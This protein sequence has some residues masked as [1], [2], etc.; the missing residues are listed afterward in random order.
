MEKKKN[1]SIENNPCVNP[2]E[3]Y[4]PELIPS[5][6]ILFATEMGTA[7]EFANQLHKE[8][9]EKLKLKA[10]I[11]NVSEVNSVQIFNENSLIVIIASTWGEGE[12]T[13]DCVDFNKMVKSKEFWDSFTNA[14]NLNVAI[15]GL[16]N[17]V[18]TFYNAQG[19]FFHKVFV[20]EHKI[21]KICELGLG[22][23]R[24]DIEKDFNDW[25]DNIFFKG[26]YSFYS[27]NYEKNYEFYK[28][29]NLLNELSNE[30]ENENKEEKNN[31][32]LYVSDKKELLQ[33]DNNNYNKNVQNRL[34]TKKVKILNIEEL[35][36]NNINGSTLRVIFDLT[37]TDIKYKPAENILVYPKNNDEA[38]NEV[39]SKLTSD[40]E[41]NFINYKINNNNKDNSLNL[42]LPEGIT[43]REALTE[44][45][46]LSCQ[47]TKN[48]LSKFVNNNNDFH[49]FHGMKNLIKDQ[50]ELDEFLSKRYNMLD[51]IKEY[52]ETKL[53]LKD[54][55]E[56]LPIISPRYYT[57][58]SSYNKNNNTIELI[59]T[60]VSWKGPNDDLRYGLTSNY[61]YNL[62]KNKTF[63]KK[64]EYVNISIKESVFSL[65]SD[66]STPI[67]M[68]CTGSG[69][70][71][72]ISFLEELEFNKSDKKYETYL[73]FGSM[74]K[75]NDFIFEKELE[76][77][78]KKGILTEYYTAFSRDQEKKVYAQNVFEKEFNKERLE[79]L[80]NNKGMKVYICGSVSMGNA[81]IKKIGEIL[82][83]E[84]KEKMIKNNQLM[85]EMWENK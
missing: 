32:E 25:K 26:L 73:I 50:N 17:T 49:Q 39:L 68:L 35:R 44:Y 81:V 29:Y 36:P 7:E 42:P 76:E 54:L 74:N 6:T 71:P 62:Y 13:D 52:N 38:I 84:N 18:Y 56:T 12:P 63:Q 40:K 77:F 43:V 22:N 30:N 24:K 51:F 8:A 78:K 70:A 46:D 64:D 75:K 27:K 65:P 72:F 67:L 31:F 79:D 2:G 1:I 37:G 82:G 16:G 10:K 60:L 58:S 3:E 20:E 80:V 4:Y 55:S 45:I 34:N 11:L 28:K 21:N 85:S 33:I 15:F 5:F 53:T 19:K 57:C 48:M 47:I 83:E 14:E 23:A 69:I 9:T 59:I 41:N 66:L 61:F